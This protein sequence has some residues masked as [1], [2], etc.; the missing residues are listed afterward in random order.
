VS[1]A[2][3]IERLRFQQLAQLGSMIAGQAGEITTAGAV[4][5]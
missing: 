1:V 5:L 3:P 4:G 2:A